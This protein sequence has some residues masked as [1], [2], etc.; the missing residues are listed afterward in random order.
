[1]TIAKVETGR[2]SYVA[3]KFECKRNIVFENILTK[4]NYVILIEPFLYTGKSI[5]YTVSSYG[6]AFVFFEEDTKINEKEHNRI[7]LLVWKDFCSRNTQLLNSKHNVKIVETEFYMWDKKK[8]VY[9]RDT[10]NSD[11]LPGE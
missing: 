7:E 3:T 1:M 5:T 6:S 4:G 8:G 2:V 9:K 11:F 10:G